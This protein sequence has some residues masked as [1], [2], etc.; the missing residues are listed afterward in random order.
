[1]SML[2]IQGR[3]Q[4]VWISAIS[5]T[6]RNSGGSGNVPNS[7]ASNGGSGG[8]ISDWTQ[9][10]RDVVP[11]EDFRRL[12]RK[13]KEM[14]EQL[15]RMQ[16]KAL[17]TIRHCR[18]NSRR[19]KFTPTEVSK[20]GRANKYFEKINLY[21]KTPPLGWEVYHPE[22]ERSMGTRLMALMSVPH[23]NDD[24]DK[25]ERDVNRECYWKTVVMPV[26]NKKFA[27]MKATTTMKCRKESN[28]EC[29]E[30]VYYCIDVA[31]YL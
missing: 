31:Q 25:E 12:D 17:I 14:E 10:V 5:M 13:N 27:D 20:M 26:A 8:T 21:V 11:L 29:R 6:N 19:D 30:L 28:S 24:D 18:N 16:S 4:I 7:V 22:N 1:M 15:K 2:N 3:G 23:D 9:S